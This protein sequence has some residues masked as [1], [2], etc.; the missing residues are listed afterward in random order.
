[1]FSSAR[2]GICARAQP[3][4]SRPVPELLPVAHACPGVLRADELGRL[5]RIRLPLWARVRKS[6]TIT[7]FL[8]L[9]TIFESFELWI[10]T[11][12]VMTYC[13]KCTW[14]GVGPVITVK[15]TDEEFP[16]AT[17]NFQNIFLRF[18]GHQNTPNVKYL[19][20]WKLFEMDDRRCLAIAMAILQN[21]SKFP[22]QRIHSV[23][24]QKFLQFS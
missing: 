18:F 5:G 22:D 20:F 2:V 8:L 6:Q 14:N 15:D 17:R 24:G 9:Y 19:P 11:Y 10:L 21:A 4:R 3:T 7:K 23:E 12:E 13:S 16:T 1:M